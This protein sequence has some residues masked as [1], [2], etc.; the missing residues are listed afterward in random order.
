MK[1]NLV[2]IGGGGHA[3]VLID[4]LKKI[5]K[6]EIIGITDSNKITDSLTGIPVIGSDEILPS[7]RNQGVECAFI[8]IGSVEDNSLRA[9]LFSKVISLGFEMINIIHPSAIIADSVEFGS[10]VAV[11]AGAIINPGAVIGNNVIINSGAIIEHDCVIGDNV[12]ICPGVNCAGGVNI[13]E[14]SHIGIGTTL[15]QC[16]NIGK[17][18]TVGAGSVVIKNIDDNFIVAGVPARILSKK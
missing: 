9:G 7:L 3:K 6:Y 1:K 13:G 4:I 15:K 18:V 2:I 17:N 10:G 11:M 12:H 14:L 8:G 5:D 16:I